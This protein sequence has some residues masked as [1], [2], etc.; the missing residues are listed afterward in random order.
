[1]KISCRIIILI[2]CLI[3]FQCQVPEPKDNEVII[4]KSHYKNGTL[5][6]ELSMLNGVRNGVSKNYYPNGALWQEVHYVNGV[7]HGLAKT[8]YKT[9]YLYLETN[10][11]QGH[12]HGIRKS[13][14]RNGNLM[15][16]IPYVEGKPAAGLKE[17]LLD[18]SEKK[19]YP[20]IQVHLLQG[21]KEYRLQFTL[22]DRVK[23]VEFYFGALDSNGN[24]PSDASMVPPN[25]DGIPE[26]V[27]PINKNKNIKETF[28]VMAR[29]TTVL[30]NPYITEQAHH[31]I[32][33]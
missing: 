4:L 5:K 6:T 27:F 11:S 21:D 13:Y 12:I 22:T 2:I 18:G 9:G 15:A 3:A 19:F 28:M 17:Y 20:S 25:E 26:L 16:E 14:R 8:Y 24:I 33:N 29:A 7:K 1:M 23:D 10:Y 31:I 32:I 30:G